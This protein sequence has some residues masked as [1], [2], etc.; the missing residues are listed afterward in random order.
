[1]QSWKL[2]RTRQC[3]KC[4]WKKSTNPLEIPHGYSKAQHEKLKETISEGSFKGEQE[5]LKIMACHESFN[6][7]P[8]MCI[9]WAHHQLNRGNNFALRIRFLVVKTVTRCRLQ[10]NSTNGL[11]IPCRK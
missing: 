11:K 10:A 7:H 4:P 1:M 5:P 8:D 6:E 9:G 2:N 3:V